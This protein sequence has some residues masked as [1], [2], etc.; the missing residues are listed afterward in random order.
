MS[1]VNDM[2]RDLEARRAAPAERE[3]LSGL[4]AA[5]ETAAARRAGFARLRRWLLVI[6]ALVLAGIALALLPARTSESVET[7]P[8]TV[9]P[10][11]P[12]SAT[13]RPLEVMPQNDVSRVLLARLL[14]RAVSVQ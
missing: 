4:Y 10:I 8:A 14:V 7:Q 6:A 13:T 3:R 2:L 12:A 5:N 1:L 11:V 9:T